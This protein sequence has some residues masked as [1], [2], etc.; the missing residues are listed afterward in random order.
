MK[1]TTKTQR[2][3]RKA[4][5]DKKRAFLLCALCAFVVSWLYLFGQATP[6]HSTVVLIT[7]DGVRWDY[8]ERDCLPAFAEMAS[9]GLSAQRF[10]PP[11]PPLT[12]ASHA[13][14]ATGCC[15]G[16]HGIVANSFLD[17]GTGERFAA[18]PDARWLLEPPVWVLAERAGLRTALAGWPVSKGPWRDVSATEW[19]PLDEERP[20]RETMAWI[21]GALRRPPA[22]RPRLVMAW[23]H[24]ADGAGHKEGPDGESVHRAMR[25]ADGLLAD[26]RGEIRALVPRVPVVLIVASDHGMAGVDHAIDVVQVV[27]KKAFY[28]YI[29]TSGAICNIYVKGAAQHEAVAEGLKRL[30]QDVKVYEKGRFP[31]ALCYG[32][33]TRV[34]DFLLV[35]PKGAFFSSFHGKEDRQ[36]SL[37]IHGYEPDDPDMR[38]IFYAEGPGVPAGKRLNAVRGI[39]VVPTI[40]A[41]LNIPPPPHA[42]GK[43]LLN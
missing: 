9:S 11:F 1:F 38:G 13:T 7:M 21:V 22:T 31:A 34:G 33:G 36:I 20:D 29:A 37:G 27:P 18:D 14:L 28:P 19:L 2:T 25:A 6:P 3:P 15:P 17:T 12:Q 5:Y 8:P 35:A 23:T 24:G 42:D 32:A 41:L 16:K 4:L 40:C 10:I 39:D 30:P 26:L 43:N